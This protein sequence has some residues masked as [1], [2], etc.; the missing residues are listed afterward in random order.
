M[1]PQRPPDRA[2]L[3]LGGL[4]LLNGTSPLRADDVLTLVALDPVEAHW[5]SNTIVVDWA[6]L[7][8][9]E[10]TACSLERDV[11][12]A[13]CERGDLL[14]RGLLPGPRLTEMLETAG[15]NR[16]GYVPICY[17]SG[18]S[19]PS[20][21]GFVVHAYGQIRF[22]EDDACF[23]RITPEPI[24]IRSITELSFLPEVI[25]RHATN[26]LFLNNHQCYY[27]KLFPGYELE[28]KY[29]L[30]GPVDAWALTADVYQRL[31][32]GK[33]PEF[34]MEYRDEFQA[35]DYMNYLFEIPAPPVEQGYVSFIPTTDGRY[36]IKRKW[37]TH[38]AFR[39][40]EEMRKG[41][42]IEGSLADYVADTLKLATVQLPAFRR[43]RYDVNFESVRTGH[44]Y[45][46]F[47]DQSTIVDSPEHRLYQ[48]ELEYL[49][50]RA[51]V[52]VSEVDVLDE[53]ELIAQWLEG[54]LREQGFDAERG[55]YSKLSFLR[56]ATAA[57]L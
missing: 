24:R 16:A 34:I 15:W 56:D 26:A 41:V 22:L 13:R 3:I 10:L 37:Y 28:H 35:W 31:R 39:R 20:D 43:V 44:V 49:R 21:E 6:R 33:L 47:F 36:T 8:H 18:I 25:A 48:C 19:A 52:P 12:A 55:V 29:T 30:A 46:I 1:R 4:H 7:G 14:F 53:L 54:F 17:L 50:T 38:D 23:V 40:R 42:V 51:V 5:P 57:A 2:W 32:F 9:V 45:G 11:I 27:R